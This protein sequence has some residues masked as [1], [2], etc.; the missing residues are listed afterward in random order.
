[1]SP[2]PNY[3]SFAEE[4]ARM[5]APL[6]A[7]NGEKADSPQSLGKKERPAYTSISARRDPPWTSDLQRCEFIKLRCFGH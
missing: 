7:G 6:E 4:G 1:M 3:C 2:P 5:R